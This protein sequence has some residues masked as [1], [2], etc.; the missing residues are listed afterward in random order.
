MEAQWDRRRRAIIRDALGIGIAVGAYGITFGALATTGG[1]SMPQTMALSSLMFTGGS[2]FAYIGVVAAGGSVVA[3]AVTALLLGARNTLYGVAM[4]PLLKTRGA[5]AA[6]AAQLTIDE[7]TA[8][9]LAHED[10]SEPRAARTAFWA[11]GV[12]VF[13]CWNI[14][15]LLGALG[16]SALGDPRSYGLDAVIP[17][18][19]LALMW[20][21]LTSRS[22]SAVAALAA[23]MATLLTVWLPA[24]LPVLAGGLVAV[25]W[26]WLAPGGGRPPS[27]DF[28]FAPLP[29]L[30]PPR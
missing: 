19:F 16:A 9:A 14:A 27:G 4:A 29:D 2:Q 22:A 6:L 1:F 30:E 25:L 26:G 17:A 23:A 21:R 5:S 13:I 12:T 7:S 24:G 3:A 11:T 28:D 20:P 15:T 8:M 10:P 18:A